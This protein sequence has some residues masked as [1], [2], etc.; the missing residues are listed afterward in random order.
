MRGATR[1][2]GM[3]ASFIPAFW[4]CGIVGLS[5]P[6]EGPG[7]APDRSGGGERRPRHFAPEQ[8]DSGGLGRVRP[9]RTRT[10]LPI[11][12]T[13]GKLMWL[14]SPLA[15]SAEERTS[16]GPKPPRGTLQERHTIRVEGV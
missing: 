16:R 14:D 7:C 11:V 3:R 4:A 1:G 13:A 10:G 8:S 15:A 6:L 5:P 9:T 2:A 12:P